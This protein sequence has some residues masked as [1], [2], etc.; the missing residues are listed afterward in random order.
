MSRGYGGAA[1]LV[2]Q[3]EKMVVYEYAPYNLNDPEYSNNNHVYDGTITIY[4]EALVEPEIHKKVIKM[5]GGRSNIIVKRIRRDVDY[6]ALLEEERIV[7]ENSNYCW[8]LIGTE[9]AVGMIALKIIF[10]IFDQYQDNG[11]IP[12]KISINY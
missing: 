8:R 10:N 6:D 1:R 9:K 12:E 3:N 2:L 5:P 4:K 7:I 11:I